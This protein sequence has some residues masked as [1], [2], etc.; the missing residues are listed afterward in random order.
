MRVIV[1][2]ATGFLGGAL[3][4]QLRALGHD[5]IAMGRNAQKLVALHV[6]GARAVALDL[7]TA[8]TFEHVAD[9]L[10][11]CA[12]LCGPWGRPEEYH[13]ANVIGTQSALNIA[14]AARVRRFVHISTP[15]VYFRFADQADV[16]EDAALPPPVNAYAR[17]KRAAETIVLA[18]TDLDPILLRPRGLYG[19]GDTTLLPR[20]IATARK[21]PLPLMRGG[22]AVTDL[23]HVD[24]VVAAII[25]ALNTK[26]ALSQRIFNISGGEALNVRDVAE[27]TA[28]RAGVKLR[29]RPLPTAFV[30]N[31]ARALETASRLHPAYPEPLITAYGA[32]LFA[33]TQTLDISAAKA[34][35]GWSPAIR[36]DE[37]LA[38]TFEARAA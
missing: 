12:A 3:T 22:R 25:A 9:A 24:D 20:L 1:T 31:Y 19:A 30:L 38:R 23:T 4:R 7:A 27:R 2:G 34:Q 14:R 18:E 28:Q 35:L 17:T 37:G 26:S 36:F 15:T 5:V 11:H 13:A 8:Q 10:V 29:W 32:A 33:F 16:R 6:I 21:R